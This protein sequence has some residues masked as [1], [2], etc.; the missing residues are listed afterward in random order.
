[1]WKFL[2]KIILPEN[3]WFDVRNTKKVRERER[4]RDKGKVGCWKIGQRCARRVGIERGSVGARCSV[5]VSLYQIKHRGY[6][7]LQWEPNSGATM[8][9]SQES[10]QKNPQCSRKNVNLNLGGVR[11][12]ARICVWSECFLRQ[13][14]RFNFVCVKTSKGPSTRKP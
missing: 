6:D 8:R 14:F 2:E 5:S 4:N 12:C 13:C 10:K 9:S 3:S 11:V 1:M 7:T